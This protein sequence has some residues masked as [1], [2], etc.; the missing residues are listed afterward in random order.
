MNA[1]K[2]L[3]PRW[4]FNVPGLTTHS[5]EAQGRKQLRIRGADRAALYG[6]RERE[7]QKESFCSLISLFM[8]KGFSTLLR[9]LKWLFVWSLQ[10]LFAAIHSVFTVSSKVL[11]LYL[12]CS[13]LGCSVVSLKLHAK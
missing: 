2:V 1:P 11:Q 5:E 12:Y 3:I 4:N 13:G 10:T 9:E 6:S 7:E 8:R